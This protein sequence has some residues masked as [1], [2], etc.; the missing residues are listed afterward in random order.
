MSIVVCVKIVPISIEEAIREDGTINRSCGKC[1]INPSDFY[2]LEAALKLKEITNEPVIVV[3]M[4]A[5]KNKEILYETIAIGADEAILLN[6]M[7][8]SGSD[9]QATSYILSKAISKIENVRIIFC[10]KQSSDGNTE[11]VAPE[12]AEKLGFCFATNIIGFKYNVNN[13]ITYVRMLND[14]IVEGTLGFP[15]LFSVNHL[16]GECRIATIK[17]IKRAAETNIVIW[18]MDNI[19]AEENKCGILGS[20]TSVAKN[21]LIK[22]NAKE[23]I[24]IQPNTSIIANYIL[25]Q[26]EN[27]QPPFYELKKTIKYRKNLHIKEVDIESLKVCRLNYNICIFAELLQGQ[28]EDTV[29]QLIGKVKEQIK[30]N[31]AKVLIVA[32]S[33][34]APSNMYEAFEYGADQIYLFKEEIQAIGNEEYYGDILAQFIIKASPSIF[35]FSATEFGRA[36][37][38]WLASRTNTGL[39]ADCTDLRFDEN[40]GILTQI[41]PVFGGDKMAEIICEVARPQMVT[42]RPNVFL[43]P[44][45]QEGV[46]GEVTVVKGYRN[47]YIKRNLTI[48]DS[49]LSELDRA[50]VVFIGGRGVGN[51]ENFHKLQCL[52]RHF[53]GGVGATRVVV[54]MG[55]ADAQMQVGLTGCYIRAQLCILFGVSG[56]PEHIAGIKNVK[57]IIAVNNDEN[58]EIFKY[59]DVKIIADVDE[60]LCEIES[61]IFL[62]GKSDVRHCTNGI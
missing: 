11:Q 6:D 16:I 51:K 7:R 61:K 55:W 41:R 23:V 3:S 25:S 36:L 34:V 48:I 53:G 10:G 47:N 8:F 28:I 46:L 31:N 26:L 22:R 17:G 30:I 50:S 42:I 39:T 62:E 32:L 52:A 45:K 13:T 59:A 33:S 9:T 40:T 15:M 56:A 5:M 38:A 49:K 29:F 37:A 24:E 18:D 1:C 14:V 58:A 35:L 57:K 27:E 2:S 54:D 19:G 12:L 44:P 43:L 20:P 4:S 60:L 21:Y